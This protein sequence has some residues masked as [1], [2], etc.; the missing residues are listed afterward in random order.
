MGAWQKPGGI[1][2]NVLNSFL[3]LTLIIFPC[4]TLAKDL[5][6]C[7]KSSLKGC[8]DSLALALNVVT[9]CALDRPQTKACALTMVETLSEADLRAPF[10]EGFYVK[11]FAI[12]NIET[13]KKEVEDLKQY[14]N[15]A[16]YVLHGLSK[17]L[18]LYYANID[19]L[20]DA[21]KN[22]I[23]SLI[24]PEFSATEGRQFNIHDKTHIR[25]FIQKQL[26]LAKAIQW[27]A[28]T[29]TN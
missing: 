21:Q 15:H 22:E 6:Y 5:G 19:Q 2:M 25:D 28:P 8:Q 18:I 17:A 9:N 29:Q 26:R 10:F 23:Q 20:T 12:G 7:P 11:D 1:N 27:G 16:W 4:I 3:S 24:Q 13:Y 14:S